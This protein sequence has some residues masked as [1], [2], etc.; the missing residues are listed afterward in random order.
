MMESPFPNNVKG[1]DLYP[2]LASVLYTCAM[3]SVVTLTETNGKPYLSFTQSGEG[4]KKGG[5]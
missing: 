5:R 3:A 1:K 2:R 4:E